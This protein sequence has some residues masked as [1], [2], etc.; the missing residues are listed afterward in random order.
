MWILTVPVSPVELSAK[1]ERKRKERN[2]RHRKL[3]ETIGSKKVAV[4][5]MTKGWG[6]KPCE[7][8]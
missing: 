8:M 2:K 5:S 7:V 6:V 1:P 3:S 4:A